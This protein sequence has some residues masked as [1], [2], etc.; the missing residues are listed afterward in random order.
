[1]AKLSK[2]AKRQAEDLI[3]VMKTEFGRRFMW[4]MLSETYIYHECFSPEQEGAR[5]VGLQLIKN[6][7]LFCP[8]LYLKMQG[9]AMDDVTKKKVE[10]NLKKVEK[11]EEDGLESVE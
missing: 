9:E 2:E 5:R 3:S 11:G 4:D 10:E 7:M 6:L 1:M 8:A